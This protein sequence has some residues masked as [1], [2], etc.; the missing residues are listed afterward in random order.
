[1]IIYIRT[2]RYFRKFST[3]SIRYLPRPKFSIYQRI[4]EQIHHLCQEN[5]TKT[6]IIE[7]LIENQKDFQ[8]IT[9]RHK[10]AGTMTLRKIIEQANT[11]KIT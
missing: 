7:A 5:E 8:N 1:M 9:K 2:D 3:T 10:K 11:Q 6:C 4:L